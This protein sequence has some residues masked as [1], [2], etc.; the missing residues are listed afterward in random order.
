MEFIVSRSRFSRWIDHN[1]R[2]PWEGTRWVLKKDHDVFKCNAELMT[3]TITS[4]ISDLI[5]ESSETHP[6][7]VL[8]SSISE[9]SEEG[10]WLIECHCDLKWNLW[11]HS[12][13]SL[14]WSSFCTPTKSKHSGKKSIYS[15][16]ESNIEI[17]IN[18]SLL[19]IYHFQRLLI[20][21][22]QRWQWDH[23]I[24]LALSLCSSLDETLC[25]LQDISY[26]DVPLEQHTFQLASISLLFVIW[27]TPMRAGDL[28][29]VVEAIAREMS[30]RAHCIHWWRA[31]LFNN[32]HIGIPYSSIP[33]K[34]WPTILHFL[35]R[36]YE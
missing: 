36:K 15:E 5:M 34:S 2:I 16:W 9:S 6:Q 7:S 24:H 29:D 13:P 10:I 26:S 19:L 32:S 8:F 28:A 30:R 23:W 22:F 12:S 4:T 27:H 31:D 11:F 14:T 1:V 17:F 3:S 33:K 20:Y 25:N 35:W 21:H 18:S